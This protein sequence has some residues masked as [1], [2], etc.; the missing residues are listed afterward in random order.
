MKKMIQIVA[1]ILLALQSNVIFA[2]ITEV[3]STDKSVEYLRYIF[4]SVVDVINGGTGPSSPDSIIGALSEVLN[5]G[6]LIFTG[7]I[8]GYTFLTGILNSAHEGNPLGKAYST[9]W[10]PLRMVF[11]LALVLPFAGGYS[12]MQIGVIWVAGHGIGL[13]NSGWNKTLDYMGASGTLYPPQVSTDFEKIAA[14]ILES[15][16][17]MHGI[18]TADRHA[19]IE[20]K[21]IEIVDNNQV[22]NIKQSAVA[23][24][25]KMPVQHRVMQRYDSRYGLAGAGVAYG[26]AFLSGFPSGIPRNY[27]SNPCGSIELKFS[28]IDE[29]MN[30]END[31]RNFQVDIISAHADLDEGLDPLARAIVLKTVDNNAPD[32]DPLAFNNSVQI[33]K[34]A[35]MKAVNDAMSAIATTRLNKWDGGNPD[36]ALT[37]LGA[38]DAGW[39]TAGA[40]YW[41]FQRINAE[42]QKMV[43]VKPEL[44]GPTSDVMDNSDYQNF[45]NTLS[46]YRVNM[47]VPDSNG[48]IVTALE[49][50]SYADDNSGLKIVLYTIQRALDIALADPDPLS[51]MAN[52]GHS[53]I[54]GFEV[55]YFAALPARG[56]ARTADDVAEGVGGLAGGARTV[57]SPILFLLEEAS[58]LFLFAALLLLPLALML[59]FYLPATPIILWIMGIAGW[60]VLVIE[61]VIA[62][63]IWAV[64]HAMPEGQGF[65][66]QRAL[67]G[68]MVLLSLFL[69]PILMLFG[70]FA[71]MVLII[72]MGR[73]VAILFIPAMSS[74]IGDSL[75]GVVSLIAMLA[76]FVAVM[77][78]I[79]HR[80][81]G[82]IHEVP[83]KV[84]RYIGG[85]AENLG[86]SNQEQQSRNIF[87]GGAAKVVSNGERSMRQDASSAASSV[88][89]K[90]GGGFGKVANA[91]KG[92][93]S[94]IGK[95]LSTSN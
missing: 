93:M 12:S 67:A 60:F 51:G 42:T 91:A 75:S 15:R 33:Y 55:A 74:M 79:A 95:M 68:Y 4:G 50:S 83:D 45:I 47:N 32:P 19:N 49:R 70:F 88:G 36:T 24:E 29:S 27:G 17:C 61:A 81:F 80:C 84:L 25:L 63:P 23:E 77:I 38:R 69:R 85:G 73:V 1:F 3:S 44:T 22:T 64:S 21:P 5:A 7:L 2:S 9:M 54:T 59:A 11:A 30:I 62:A 89:Q 78:Q 94:K 26:A 65:V 34:A 52:I 10:I 28:E 40:W 72:V 39:L 6:M 8:I 76:I 37:T 82:L 53:I 46:N 92:G 16:V 31:V 13:A 18:N 87:V 56:A 41:D 14:Q 20:E 35:Y 86:E 57:T 43:S 48:N 90:M 71:A 58:K 66:G